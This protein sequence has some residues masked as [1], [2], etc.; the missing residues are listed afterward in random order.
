MN[1]N[2]VVKGVVI[3]N[4]IGSPRDGDDY[5]IIRSGIRKYS[6][7][8]N[9]GWIGCRNYSNLAQ[10]LKVKDQVEVY[11]K[12]INKSIEVCDSDIFYIKKL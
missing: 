11:G 8:Y 2:V 4:V 9:R 10:D 6:I 7:T 5:I 1:K 3:E 12:R